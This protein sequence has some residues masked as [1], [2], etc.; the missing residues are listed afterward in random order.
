MPPCQPLCFLLADDP[1]AGRTIMAGL[2]KELI[3]RG[4]IKRCLRVCPRRLVATGRRPEQQA[5][6]RQMV[7]GTGLPGNICRNCF[8]YWRLPTRRQS[9]FTERG[10][11]A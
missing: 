8:A 10:M 11:P 5:H 4:D 3:A 1:G 6:T 9:S 7:G 2:V